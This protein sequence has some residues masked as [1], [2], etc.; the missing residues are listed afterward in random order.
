MRGTRS[1]PILQAV[2]FVAMWVPAIA[3]QSKPVPPTAVIVSDD[4][5]PMHEQWQPVASA[6]SPLWSVGGGTYGSRGTGNQIS[7]ITSY[8]GLSPADPPTQKLNSA[9]YTF[10]ARMRNRAADEQTRVGLVYQYQDALNYYRVSVSSA[11]IV[12][13]ERVLNGVSTTVTGRFFGLEP[14]FW[15]D[16]E[17]QWN[18]GRT[19]L[20]IDGVVAF[21]GIQ[22]SEFTSGQVGLHADGTW[23]EFDNVYVGVPFGDQPF[24]ETLADGIAQGFVPVSGK[25]GVSAGTYNDAAVQATSITLAPIHTSA[26]GTRSLTLRARMLNPYGNSGNRLG[27]VFN[28][29]A[30]GSRVEYN[31]LVFSATGVARINRV[32]NGTTQTL[33]TAPYAGARNKWFEVK[34]ELDTTLTATVDGTVVFAN[35]DAN[36][37]DSP[38]GRVGLI[39]HFT[40]GRFDDISF[41]H[42]VFQGFTENFDAGL[43]ASA[44]RVGSWSATGGVLSNPAIQQ[45]D[46]VALGCCLNTELVYRA[47]LLNQYGASGNLV[48]LIY[49]YQDAASG[50]NAGDYYEVVFSTTGSVR[51]NKFIQ[52]ELRTLA[53][54]SI[55]IPRNTWFDVEVVR[56]GFSTSVKVNG[57]T[58][59]NNV[60]QAQLGPGRVGVITHWSK[61][62]FDDLSVVAAAPEQFTQLLDTGIGLSPAE[63]SCPVINDNGQVAVRVGWLSGEQSIVRLAGD[64]EFTNIVSTGPQPSGEEVSSVAFY[65]L[66]IDGSG[67]VFTTVGVPGGQLAIRGSAAGYQVLADTRTS[68]FNDISAAD[69]NDAGLSLLFGSL[70]DGSINFF[71]LGTGGQRTVY[72]P[73]DESSIFHGSFSG[74]RLDSSGTLTTGATYRVIEDGSELFVVGVFTIEPGGAP[75]LRLNWSGTLNNISYGNLLVPVRNEHD[76][77]AVGAGLGSGSTPGILRLKGGVLS[78]VAQAQGGINWFDPSGLAINDGSTVVYQGAFPGGGVLFMDTGAVDRRIIGTGDALAGSTVGT[79]LFCQGGLNERN[80]IT[81]VA[82]LADGRAGVFVADLNKPGTLR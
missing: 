45:T 25:W 67:R 34:F 3:A 66:A 9:R 37:N 60:T 73:T 46:L 33:A 30:S 10:R 41:D 38:A 23:G 61:G 2:T 39:T 32:V 13:L 80:Q 50:L 49:N 24:S 77:I 31:E 19:T 18:R 63:L 42:G 53:T 65:G 14:K 8:A 11:H 69:M 52:G 28:Y 48:G 20:K 21:S 62:R 6:G 68:D 40:P 26:N 5:E 55:N 56:R 76:E 17:L 81:F 36:P 7:V 59:I 57:T 54:S 79:L 15:M 1:W 44:V 64:G 12:S 43:P 78:V 74:A 75:I 58:L 29:I 4:F 70:D 47:R 72:L 71:G 51:V 82:Q 16:L 22:Q 35:V 27:I